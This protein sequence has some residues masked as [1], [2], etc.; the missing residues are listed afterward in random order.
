MPE[1]KKK[2]VKVPNIGIVAFPHEMPDDK[3]AAAIKA[4]IARPAKPTY[5]AYTPPAIER[6]EDAVEMQIKQA[7]PYTGPYGAAIAS[8]PAHEPHIIE[9]NDPK[10]FAMGPKQTVGHELIHL[11]QNNLAGPIQQ[12]IP[13]DDPKKPYDISDADALRKSGKKLWN[14]PKE[15]AATIVQYYI[16][17]PDARARLQPWI[18]DLNYAPLSLVNPTGPNDKEINITPRVPPPPIEAYNYLESLKKEA[19]RYRPKVVK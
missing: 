1:P 13:P 5:E 3:V 14:L 8:V 10:K 16:A 15:K 18:D 9:I 19:Q 17:F 6:I 7:G 4:H 12:A 11:L 2:L